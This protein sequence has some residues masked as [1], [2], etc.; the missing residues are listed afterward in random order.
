MINSFGPINFEVDF[1]LIWQFRF[2][3]QWI[4][5]LIY[6]R[7]FFQVTSL[8]FSWRTYM[9]LVLMTLSDHV[10][11]VFLLTLSQ[12][13]FG[14][15]LCVFPSVIGGL[16]VV[17]YKL[18]VEK[19]AF[20]LDRLWSYVLAKF[21]SWLQQQSGC[22]GSRIQWLNHQVACVLFG[23]FAL[24]CPSVLCL[25]PRVLP[26]SILAKTDIVMLEKCHRL[27]IL[28]GYSCLK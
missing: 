28:L 8:P 15:N 1:S 25:Q 17:W 21:L 20:S 18:T 6:S 23:V 27:S 10:R 2:L 19:L 14:A 24:L 13:S 5:N 22:D 9:L 3:Y 7:P 12:T 26:R 16:H 4:V 11:I